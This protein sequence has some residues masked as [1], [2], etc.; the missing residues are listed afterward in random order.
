[1][2]SAVIPFRSASPVS[3]GAT[4]SL[5][6]IARPGLSPEP[7]GILLVDDQTGKLS[8]RTRDAGDFQDLEEQDADFLAALASDLEAKGLVPG[9]GH[10][11]LFFQVDCLSVVV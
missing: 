4:W 10:Y 11:M 7:L 1:M 8:L 6:E 5:L 2:P 9:A 3:R